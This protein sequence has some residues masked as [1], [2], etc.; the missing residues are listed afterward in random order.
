MGR[1]SKKFVDK[2]DPNTYTF[3]LVHRS[4]RDPRLMDEE[5][6][7]FVLQEIDTGGKAQRPDEVAEELF[8]SGEE[9]EFEDSEELRGEYARKEKLAQYGVYYDD[10][11]DYMQHLRAR[12]GGGDVEVIEANHDIVEERLKELGLVNKRL[13]LDLP[14][15]VLPPEE[16]EDVG[17]LN[18]QIVAGPLIGWDPDIVAVLDGALDLED[19]DNMLLDDFILQANGGLPLDGSQMAFSGSLSDYERDG[20]EGEE[21]EGDFDST[22]HMSEDGEEEGEEEEEDETWLD[23]LKNI[24]RSKGPAGQGEE[25]KSRFTEYSMTSSILPRNDKLQLH[26]ARFEKLFEEYD[27]EKIG[28]LDEEEEGS[29]AG[30]RDVNSFKDV[31]DDFLAQQGEQKRHF[32]GKNAKVFFP[33]VAPYVPK[34]F[35]EEEKERLTAFEDAEEGGAKPDALQQQQEEAQREEEEQSESDPD[36]ETILSYTPY[37]MTKKPE[38][39][40]E[41]ILSTRSNLYNHPTIIA[42]KRVSK[43]KID[44]HGIPMNIL[45]KK[46]EQIKEEDEEEEAEEDGEEEEPVNKGVARSKEESKEEKKA[47]KQAIK[48]ERKNRRATKKATKVA[49]KHEEKRQEKIVENTR[50]NLQGIKL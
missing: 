8:E 5:A 1:K 41:S 9:G 10:D 37:K 15:D 16:E 49:F 23:Q 14:P 27:E 4:Q 30:K 21:E 29:A 48:E 20:E 35:E 2:K 32:F 22:G 17:M 13:P 43:I 44:K 3:R 38:H 50:L 33:K 40:C 24:R 19:E 11:Y 25:T 39:D 46:D 31:F 26:D 18:Q 47:R 34:T 6:G 12:G 42:E 7:Q 28:A 45:G 36:E